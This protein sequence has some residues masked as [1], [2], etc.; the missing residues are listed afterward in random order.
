MKFYD[1][2]Q[3]TPE[4]EKLR[5]GIATASSF[6]RILTPKKLELSAQAS[7]YANELIAERILNQKL[8]KFR[9]HVQCQ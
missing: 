6:N 5:I 2:A 1:V 3:Q 8:E 7:D 9:A 4:W